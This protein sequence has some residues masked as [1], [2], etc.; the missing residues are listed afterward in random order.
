[1]EVA[2]LVLAAG[3]APARLVAA[4]VG[5]G[6]GLESLE[7]LDQYVVGR[8]SRAAQQ[9]QPSGRVA[10]VAG[11]SGEVNQ[12]RRPRGVGR[13]RGVVSRLGLGEVAQPLVGLAAQPPQCRAS[14]PWRQRL[15]CLGE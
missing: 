9:R 4:E 12:R 10:A 14:G 7:Q 5:P 15:E 3:S 1:M 6:H 8:G 2:F 13:L 11:V